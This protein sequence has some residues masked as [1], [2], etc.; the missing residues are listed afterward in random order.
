MNWGRDREYNICREFGLGDSEKYGLRV[1]HNCLGEDIG[2][3]ERQKIIRTQLANKF[4][5][6]DDNNNR[7]QVGRLIL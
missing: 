1:R 7:I 4:Y 3:G 5:R 6:P 2:S